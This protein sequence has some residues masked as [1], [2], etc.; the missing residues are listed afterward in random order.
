MSSKQMNGC[1]VDGFSSIG[2][3]YYKTRNGCMVLRI[4]GINSS[5]VGLLILYIYS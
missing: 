3:G 1:Q 5:I 4:D 2:I